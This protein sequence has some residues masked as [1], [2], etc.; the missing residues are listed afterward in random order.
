MTGNYTEELKYDELFK[1]AN[2]IPNMKIVEYNGIFVPRIIP[3]TFIPSINYFS[4]KNDNLFY[5][6]CLDQELVSARKHYSKKYFYSPS[7]TLIATLMRSNEEEIRELL[8]DNDSLNPAQSELI[9]D[10]TVSLNFASIIGDLRK[11]K[12]KENN[13]ELFSKY[14]HLE[15][16]GLSQLILPLNDV[17]AYYSG[18]A[19]NAKVKSKSKANTF[20]KV[21]G[22]QFISFD[23]KELELPPFF[24]LRCGCGLSEASNLKYEFDEIV[25]IADVHTEL[26][27]Q[28]MSYPDLFTGRKE[29][30]DSPGGEQLEKIDNIF[31]PFKP[32]DNPKIYEGNYGKNLRKI[33]RNGLHNFIVSQQYLKELYDD[34]ND[35]HKTNGFTWFRCELDAFLLSFKQIYDRD[36]LNLWKKNY[37]PDLSERKTCEFF[38]DYIKTK[39]VRNDSITHSLNKNKKTLEHKNNGQAEVVEHYAKRLSDNVTGQLTNDQMIHDS[40]FN[41][42]L[43]GLN[44]KD[45][46]I[47]H[48]APVYEPRINFKTPFK[49]AKIDNLS[50]Y[51]NPYKMKKSKTNS[52]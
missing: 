30:Y 1:M 39:A 11:N 15:E 52:N 4:R 45:Y 51:I 44:P 18:H 34:P 16:K 48:V 2:I 28:K 13:A 33:L 24:Q 7:S 31:N 20:Y 43:K 36:F 49:A 3:S 26:A 22:K 21:E 46:E 50:I 41:H 42:V 35:Y 14:K 29:F 37:N 6:L 19:F 25:L 12:S 38:G 10:I 32:I 17:D 27:R 23:G 9:E 47:F 5:C 40:A 8:G